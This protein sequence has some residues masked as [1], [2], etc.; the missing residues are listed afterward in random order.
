VTLIVDGSVVETLVGPA[1]TIFADLA[2][3]VTDIPAGGG[4]GTIT[5]DPAGSFHLGLLTGGL[6]LDLEDAF[7]SYVSAPG[8][9]D[10]VYS[11]AAASIAGQDLPFGLEIGEPV[12]MSFSTIIDPDSLMAVGM[13]LEAFTASG[14]GEIM[15]EAVPE[16]ASILLLLPGLALLLAS[17]RRSS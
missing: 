17:R 9:F 2:V 12:T 5:S 13:Y 1:D 8:F 3:A 7:V 11:G 16:P 14:T 15:G 10:L 6:T 4:M